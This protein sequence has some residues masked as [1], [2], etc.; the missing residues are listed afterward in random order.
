MKEELARV[1]VRLWEHKNGASVYILPVE[2]H[3]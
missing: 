1:A 2:I 3:I